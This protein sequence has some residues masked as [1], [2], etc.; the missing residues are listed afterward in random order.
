MKRLESESRQ[1]NGG[2]LSLPFHLSEIGESS[3]VNSKVGFS[4]FPASG[5]E[6]LAKK[7]IAL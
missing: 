3:I 1:S 6:D 5:K 4:H 2:V 7:V